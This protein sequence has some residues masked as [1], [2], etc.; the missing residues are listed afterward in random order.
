M[1]DKKYF[2][3]TDVAKIC[4]IGTE[5]VRRRCKNLGLKPVRRIQKR[6]YYN[7]EQ[8]I[9]IQNYQRVS[10]RVVEVIEVPKL[11]TKVIEYH[12]Y[13]SKLNYTKLEDL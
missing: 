7:Y 9:K 6:I 1:K 12:F 3:I 4:E 2:N 5:Q 8:L 13:E 11:I 10:N